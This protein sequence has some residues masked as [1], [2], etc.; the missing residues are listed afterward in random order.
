MVT[1]VLVPNGLPEVLMMATDA[2]RYKANG[3]HGELGLE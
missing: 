1:G 3:R 2:S